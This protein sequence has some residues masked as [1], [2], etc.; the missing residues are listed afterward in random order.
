MI[1]EPWA[2][3]HLSQP[4]GGAEKCMKVWP[5]TK[6]FLQVPEKM[7][8]CLKTCFAFLWRWSSRLKHICPELQP[9]D[10]V[11]IQLHRCLLCF[12]SAKEKQI[13]FFKNSQLQHHPSD[14]SVLT[15]EDDFFL[16]LSLVNRLTLMC[17][18]PHVCI[19]HPVKR[20]FFNRALWHGQRR[21]M[22]STTTRLYYTSS[23]MSGPVIKSQQTP[24][25]CSWPGWDVAVRSSC[26]I[27]P[28]W[29]CRYESDAGFHWTGRSVNSRGASLA[30]QQKCV[31]SGWSRTICSRSEGHLLPSDW[32]LWPYKNLQNCACIYSMF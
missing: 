27:T 5:Q 4:T 9:T 1:Y 25:L 13:C 17:F 10:V 15:A 22:S 8:L 30:F 20:P 28:K 26:F 16:P 24:L 29:A 3:R 12:P 14:F 6:L 7:T 23:F 18:Y 2:H 19:K 31:V 32:W 11:F 21:I